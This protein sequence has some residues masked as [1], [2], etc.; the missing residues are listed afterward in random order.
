MIALFIFSLYF[1]LN[2]F[3]Y[4]CAQYDSKLMPSFKALYETTVDHKVAWFFR[5][6][7][8]VFLAMPFITFID[9]NIIRWTSLL[10]SLAFFFS[11]NFRLFLNKKRNA[12]WDY[13]SKDSNSYDIFFTKLAGKNG[14]KLAYITEFILII[15]GL[16]FYLHG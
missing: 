5:G 10:V 6:L 3:T 9:Y 11:F 13:I 7:F 1:C 16:F 8:T 2:M 12:K 15:I 14:G 4:V